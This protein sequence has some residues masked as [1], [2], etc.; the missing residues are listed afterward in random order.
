M[1]MK[2]HHIAYTILAVVG[3]LYIFHM[4]KS[5]GTFSGA[6]SGLGVSK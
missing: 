1:T 2:K 4:Y 3:A 5:H 6:L